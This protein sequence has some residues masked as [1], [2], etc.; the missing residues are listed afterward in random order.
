MRGSLVGTAVTLA[1]GTMLTAAMTTASASPPETAAQAAPAQL[2]QPVLVDCLWHRD[3]RPADFVLACGDGNS[4]LTGLRW[5][6]WSPQAADAEGVNVVNDCKPYCAA[7]TFRSYRV[8]VRLDRP[9]PWKKHPGTQ[10][11]TRMSLTYTGARPEG[12]QQVMT[13]PLWD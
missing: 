5:T 7:G 11:Y 4:R 2:T 6:R 8:T 1:A 12:F 9:E 13:Y 10:H 3:V